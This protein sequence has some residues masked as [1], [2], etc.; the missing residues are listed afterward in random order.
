MKLNPYRTYWIVF[1]SDG[2]LNASIKRILF[3][4]YI[5]T[6]YEN[7]FIY[8]VG[9]EKTT[10]EEIERIK[11]VL[12]NNNLEGRLFII[13]DK[14]FGYGQLIFNG[15]LFTAIKPFKYYIPLKNKLSTVFIPL[16]KYQQSRA[17]II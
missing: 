12:K 10:K 11:T 6:T 13:T 7:G 16:T 15:G 14:Q 5:F 3:K 9:N 17:I 8:L 2:K 4:Y 1:L